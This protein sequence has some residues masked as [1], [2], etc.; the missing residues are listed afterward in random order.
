MRGGNHCKSLTYAYNVCKVFMLC[1]RLGGSFAANSETTA[2]RYFGL[3]ELP[4][5][6]EEKNTREQIVM[7]FNAQADENWKVQ[8]D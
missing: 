7:C 3:D 2:S 8:F 6:A 4:P 1:E 5:L